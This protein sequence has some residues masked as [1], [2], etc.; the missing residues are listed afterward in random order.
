MSKNVN[1]DVS[2]DLP[3]S[4]LGFDWFT[5]LFESSVIDVSCHLAWFL[6]SPN[7]KLLCWSIGQSMNQSTL[8]A[9]ELSKLDQNWNVYGTKK[10]YDKLHFQKNNLILNKCIRYIY[11]YRTW[12]Y[13][14][15]I[16][17]KKP[18]CWCG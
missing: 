12:F 16:R 7:S 17:I 13:D 11:I 2:K 10:L 3:T 18:F 9:Q 5:E 15:Q 8:C 4:T 1:N 14:T 6:T